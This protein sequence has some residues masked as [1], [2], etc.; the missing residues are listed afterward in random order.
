MN[1]L[2]CIKG[3]PIIHINKPALLKS[4]LLFAGNIKGV[5]MRNRVSKPASQAARRSL[6]MKLP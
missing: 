4:D 2:V 1:I 3:A 6:S 5:T